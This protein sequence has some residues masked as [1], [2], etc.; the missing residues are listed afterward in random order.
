[1]SVARRSSRVWNGKLLDRGGSIKSPAPCVPAQGAPTLYEQT[2]QY[3]GVSDRGTRSRD[4]RFRTGTDDT[5]GRVQPSGPLLTADTD[6]VPGATVG[7]R[8]GSD[9]RGLLTLTRP[10]SSLNSVNTW[11]LGVAMRP[12]AWAHH[13][14]TR[15]TTGHMQP[16]TR[17][18]TAKTAV[19][20]RRSDDDRNR[21]L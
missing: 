19:Q 8:F 14:N 7:A 10:L 16:Y 20:P 21:R 18:V 12:A 15:V 2:S 6:P 1:M 11:R 13:P 17:P 3:N 5:I 9:T 4:A